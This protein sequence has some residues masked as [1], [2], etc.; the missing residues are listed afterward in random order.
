MLYSFLSAVKEEVPDNEQEPGNEEADVVSGQGLD[1]ATSL[2][3]K[4]IYYG[5]SVFVQQD[6][7]DH[8]EGEDADGEEEDFDMAGEDASDESDSEDQEE[9]GKETN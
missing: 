2:P 5:H 8:E 6:G 7:S 3:G 4:Y 1:E 9:K